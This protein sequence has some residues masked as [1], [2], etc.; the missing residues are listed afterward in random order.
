VAI[1]TAMQGY[2]ASQRYFAPLLREWRCECQV[3]QS[4]TASG[5][6]NSRERKGKLAMLKKSNLKCTGE[7][8]GNRKWL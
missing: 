3:S 6:Q 7:G 1:N 2:V 4:V 8:I 5:N